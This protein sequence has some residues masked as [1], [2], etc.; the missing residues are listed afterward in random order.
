MNILKKAGITAVS[1]AMLISSVSCF[2]KDKNEI[3]SELEKKYG[4]NFS[5]VDEGIE[6]GTTYLDK[7]KNERRGRDITIY[8][9]KDDEGNEFE[10]R[11]N[12]TDFFGN[13]F[14][15]RDNYEVVYFNAHASEY[16]SD[17]EKAGIKIK[18]D[19]EDVIKFDI[20]SYDQIGDAINE[21][22]KL[23]QKLNNDFSSEDSFIHSYPEMSY[24]RMLF[25]HGSEK[26]SYNPYD[27]E[28]LKSDYIQKIKEGK[29]NEKL[30]E[31]A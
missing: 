31:G 19:G 7:G 30:P 5:Y 11:C 17:A 23:R 20:D 29:I 3:E 15:Y 28:Q 8:Y 12:E 21:A 10:V 4:K 14:Y 16:L 2:Q 18:Y 27:E 9:Y 22:N 25:Y 6:R 26:V 13:K 24:T 1:T